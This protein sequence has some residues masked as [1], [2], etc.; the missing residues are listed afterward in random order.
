MS[1]AFTLGN[2][3]NESVLEV[4]NLKVYYG[5]ESNRVR[6]VDDINF[7]VA[8]GKTLGLVGESGC[9][10]SSC[11]RAILHLEPIHSGAVLYNGEN[12]AEISEGEFK[13]YRSQIQ[14]VFQDPYSSLN[15]RLTTG[16][17]LREVIALHHKGLDRSEIELQ[18]KAVLESV[19]MR[20]ESVLKYPHEFSGGQRQRIG[21]ARALAA[22]P[23]FLV[24]DEV[25]SALDVSVQAQILNLLRDL[26]INNGLSYLFI[27]HDLAVV[28]HLCH[29]VAVM[30]YGKIVEYGPVAQIF[31]DPQHPYTRLLLA[32]VPGSRRSLKVTEQKPFKEGAQ[33]WLD[34]GDAIPPL[35]EIQQGYWVRD[36]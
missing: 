30:Y 18:V 26:Q 29:D 19:G 1:L 7:K 17:V 15:P 4:Q 12:L 31:K 22:G 32:S 35:R 27:S 25:V 23:K 3:M 16:T 6:A 9:G 20:G 10:K 14:M 8:A 11:G 21:I 13:P 24:L 5:K 33:V 28:R 34:Y 2:L 36:V